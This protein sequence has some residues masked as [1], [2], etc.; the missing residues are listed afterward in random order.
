[1]TNRNQTINENSNIKQWKYILSKDNPDD[2]GSRGLDATKIDK[3]TRWFKGP[4]FLW[5]PESEW[6]ISTEFQPPNE[7]DP[8]VRKEVTVNAICIEKHN[9]LYT[10]EE[11]I[12]CWFKMWRNLH[13]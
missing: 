8:E 9:I 4:A 1:M 3:V 2:D 10:L 12:S 7:D 5:K 6:T 11:K 13:T